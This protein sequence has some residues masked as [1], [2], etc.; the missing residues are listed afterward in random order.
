MRRKLRNLVSNAAVFS[1]VLLL[2]AW[3]YSYIHSLTLQWQ[4]R[5]YDGKT[6]IDY[7]TSL[8][9]SRGVARPHI[10]AVRETVGVAQLDTFSDSRC[11]LGPAFDVTAP[12]FI[13]NFLGFDAWIWS[14]HKPVQSIY[15]IDLWLPGWLLLVPLVVIALKLRASAIRR[16]RRKLGQCAACG[17]DL[18]ASGERCPECGTRF[19]TTTAGKKTD[20]AEK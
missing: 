18:R 3:G 4:S 10:Y 17:Y 1:F 5:H 6:R 16:H 9:M 15:N 19:A 11:Y 12:H 14:W 8:E 13:G 20:D 2:G 7:E